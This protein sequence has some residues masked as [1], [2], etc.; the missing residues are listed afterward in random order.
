MGDDRP[1]IA[2]GHQAWLWHPGILAKYIAASE[3]ARRVGGRVLNVV[4]D[5]DVHEALGLELPVVA[6]GRLSVRCVQLGPQD[7]AIPTGMHPPVDAGQVVNLLQRTGAGEQA[8]LP[9]DLSPLIEAWGQ[10]RGACDNLAWQISGVLEHLMR[11]YVGRVSTVLASDLL[12]TPAAQGW[13]DRMLGD[14][15]G[16]VEAY[17]RAAQRFPDARVEALLVEPGR[18]ELPLWWNDTRASRKDAAAGVRSRQRVF[19]DLTQSR[20]VLILSHGQLVP[21]SE[22][23]PGG[24]IGLAPRALLMTALVR[25]EF[26]DLFVHGSGG[27][28][29][30]RVTEQWCKE[31]LDTDLAPRVTVSADLYLGFD[32]PVADPKDLDRARWWVHHLPHNVDR[33]ARSLEGQ[34]R[35]AA[36]RKWQLIQQMNNDRDRWRRAES[37]REIHEIN[38]ALVGSHRGLIRKAKQ[39]L[40]QTQLGVANRHV[41][42]KRDWCFGLYPSSMIVQLRKALVR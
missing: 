25:S 31:W 38:R 7:T 36:A 12:T 37:F 29:Y 22:D 10:D 26:C 30:D 4:V 15:R 20:P 1:V 42:M 6:D 17:N 27:R 8:N 21:R 23:T 35:S 40:D 3:A 19:V 41:A 34:E 39:D 9:V 11:P 16:C 18:V 13:V 33:V 32:A 2:V 5:Q 28:L 24:Y 14:A